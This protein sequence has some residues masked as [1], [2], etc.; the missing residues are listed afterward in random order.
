MCYNLF[1]RGRKQCIHQQI[2]DLRGEIAK[3]E[4]RILGNCHGVD[5]YRRM[6]LDIRAVYDADI[7]EDDAEP[8]PTLRI[9]EL[10]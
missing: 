2:A 9:L 5:L 1:W 3:E 6:L 7:L 8:V 10:A 4:A